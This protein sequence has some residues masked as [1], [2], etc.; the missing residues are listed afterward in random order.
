MERNRTRTL[1]IVK[2]GNIGGR[3]DGLQNSNEKRFFA[4]HAAATPL[5]SEKAV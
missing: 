4:H 2:A 5:G 3:S 1:D